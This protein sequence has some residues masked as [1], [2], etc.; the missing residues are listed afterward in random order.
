VNASG[1]IIGI[2][3]TIH[4][5]THRKQAEEALKESEFLFRSQFDLGNIGIA[6]STP[7]KGYIRVNAKLRQMLGYSEDELRGLTWAEMTHPD[8]LPENVALFDRMISGEISSYEMD[9]RFFRK[10]GGIVH[11]HL[12]SSC[13]RGPDGSVRFVIASML[14]ISERK[15]M[16][17]QLIESEERLRL[18]LQAANDGL[19]DWHI[20]SGRVYFSPRYYTLLGYEPG[21]FPASNESWLSLLHPDDRAATVAGVARAL[22]N[23][24]GGFTL[25]FRMH[26][27]QGGWIWLLARAK[28]VERDESGKPVRVVGTHTDIAELKRIKTQQEQF[29]LLSADLLCIAGLD[30]YFKLLSPSWARTLG[31][32]IEELTSRPFTE[33]VHP[34]DRAATELARGQLAHGERIQVFENR[35]RTS[36]GDYRWLSWHSL[37]VV[38][39]GL[40]IGVA[41]DITERRIAEEKRQRLEAQVRHV[42]KLESL[43]VLAGGIAH[44][45]NNLLM[46]VMGNADLALM[47]LPPGS[48]VRHNLDEIQK[49]ASRAADLCRQMLAYS[50]KGRFVL[51]HVNLSELV[52]DM[53]NLLEVSISKSVALRYRFAA[54]LPLIEADVTQVR[55]IIMNLIINASEAIGDQNGVITVSTGSMECSRS[56]LQEAYIDEALPEGIYVYLEV[57]DTGCGMDEATRFKMF[58]PFYSTKFTGRGLGLAAV[59][60]IVRGHKGTVKVISEPGK[61]TT[62]RVLFPALAHQLVSVEPSSDDAP[63]RGAGLVLLVDDEETVRAVARAMLEKLGFRVLTARDGVEAVEIFRLQSQTITCVVLDLTMPRMDGEETFRRL[64]QLRPG[65]PVVIS[66]GYNEQEVTQRFVGQ[67]LAGFIQKPYDIKCLQETLEKVLQCRQA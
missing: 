41:R 42:Q 23:E 32:S 66:S 8:D 25:E 28:V 7:D 10:D 1:D 48:P 47:G 56:Y 3:A 26:A 58:D 50:G 34:D 46:G 53:A 40:I 6:I 64:R 65:V 11:T 24:E 22:K 15:R 61:G 18:A 33:F 27:K 12:T 51:D 52:R 21:E 55:Q 14:D 31:W 44:D 29:F 63:S 62:F 39:D 2:L 54:S 9:K 20:P 60:G 59:L 57:A 67:G 45:F 37:A 17:E 36:S 38:E 16:E 4:D 35:F 43:G 30:G 49:A 5:I 13:Y 19:W